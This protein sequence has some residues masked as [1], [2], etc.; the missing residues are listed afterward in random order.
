MTVTAD[1][2]G[3]ISIHAPREGER[4]G[5]DPASHRATGFQSTL[6]AR[7]ATRLALSRMTTG[8]DF[9]PRSPR[10][11]RPA[12][13]AFAR[14]AIYFNPRSP[15]GERLGTVTAKLWRVSYFNPRSPRGERPAA[16][17]RFCAAQNFNPRSPR[18]E[19]L[20]GAIRRAG[21]AISIHAPREGSDAHKPG[22]I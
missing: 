17:D 12:S 1:K 15:R 21:F 9:N 20:A 13:T 18:G 2:T 11:E 19:R 6:P 10:G 16:T 7:G 14:F 5:E 22:H 3:H 8:P 4:L